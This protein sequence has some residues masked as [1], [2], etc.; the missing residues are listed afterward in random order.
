VRARCAADPALWIEQL[1]HERRA[2]S[3]RVGGEDRRAAVE[4]A[5][6]LRDALG[7]AIPR[8]VPAAFA[9]SVAEPLR[10]LVARYARTHGPFHAA[11]VARRFG[12]PL[13]R[14][15]EALGA[16]EG[17]G[18]IVLGEFRPGGMERE[19]CDADVLRT[20]RR[21]S[22]AALRKEIEPVDGDALARF[23]P[24]WHGIGHPRRGPGA[25]ADAID[26][27]QGAAIPAS[28]LESDVLP[29]R[30]AGYRPADLD[31]LCAAG[32]IVWVGAGPLG[33]DD[34]RVALYFRDR[35]ALLAPEPSEDRPHDPVHHAL[36]RH[37]AERGAS[38]WAELVQAAGTAEETTVLTALWDLVWAGEVTNDT[39]APLRAFL[40]RRPS[41]A[42]TGKPRPGALRRTGP[43]AGQGRWSLVEPL[44]RPSPSATEAAHTRALQLLDRH[45]V[46]TREAVLAEGTPGGFASV[47]GVLKAMEESGKVRRG[48]FVAGLG[49]AQFALP[50][51]VD[52]LR[53]LREAPEGSAAL[54]L[55]ATDPAQ[56]YGAALPWPEGP[57]R[58][59]RAAGAFVVLAS[60]ALV[61]YLERGARSLLTFS[62]DDDDP[63]WMDALVALAKD[64]RMR[65][66]Q[67]QRIDG[68]AA[69]ESPWAGH[70]RERGFVEG[71]R[72][73]TLRD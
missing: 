38:F 44:L 14:V 27:L 26:Q 49:A 1:L 47:Y 8:G 58:P 21:R 31:A 34:G 62:G 23:L 35:A 33:S 70:L 53:G 36:R 45:G 68:L 52:R 9:A 7:A 55:G 66:I 11:D 19:W 22:L 48:Y 17:E 73:L 64:G 65:R 28:V 4:D 2:I 18:R 24:E 60:G 56:P 3:V 63:A 54:A 20:L 67:L 13:E 41:R 43:P 29:V 42:A 72:G 61:A 59:A 12:A 15:T 57:G 10:E 32:E 6:R 30:V 46:V 39:L 40:L 37:L 5:G 69:H 50:G 51:A 16:L 71:Y 25:L